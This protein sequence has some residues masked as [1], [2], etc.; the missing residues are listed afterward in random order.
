MVLKA[1]LEYVKLLRDCVFWKGEIMRLK[2]SRP[3]WIIVKVI[4]DPLYLINLSPYL[5][6]RMLQ[7]LVLNGSSDRCGVS[8]LILAALKKSDLTILFGCPPEGHND[9][10]KGGV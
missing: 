1:F 7:K 3:L 5:G 8:L 9:W 6:R 2:K 10:I 4:Q